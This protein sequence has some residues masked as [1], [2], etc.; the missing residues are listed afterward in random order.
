MLTNE[1]GAVKEQ[2]ANLAD[3]LS[4]LV[5]GERQRQR[6]EPQKKRTLLQIRRTYSYLKNKL[7]KKRKIKQIVAVNINW[8]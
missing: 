7:K 6:A 2:V 4:Q 8:I 1:Y 5:D 3:T